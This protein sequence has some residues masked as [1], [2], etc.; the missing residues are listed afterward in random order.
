MMTPREAGSQQDSGRAPN[1]PS[2]FLM[3]T[4][5][6]AALPPDL[7]LNLGT[8]GGG[9]LPPKRTIGQHPTRRQATNSK[10]SIRVICV[11][12]LLE[13]T[14]T[15]RPKRTGP[16]ILV[17]NRHH[18]HLISRSGI[19]IDTWAALS[20]ADFESGESAAP[21]FPSF[22]LPGII[23]QTC[24]RTPCGQKSGTSYQ[25]IDRS[26]ASMAQIDSSVLWL[27]L[28]AGRGSPPQQASPLI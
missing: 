16:Q 8:T 23:I 4:T 7:C 5:T 11:G 19:W 6:S 10:N 24:G 9:R 26:M 21:S 18:L 25:S 17:R 12:R 3:R 27:R 2:K 20:V 13:P 22:F 15:G 28:A 14:N 1:P